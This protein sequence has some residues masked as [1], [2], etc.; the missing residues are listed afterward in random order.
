MYLLEPEKL[1]H[2]DYG[3]TPAEALRNCI[4]HLMV[5][6]PSLRDLATGRGRAT[7]QIFYAHCLVRFRDG[8]D[9][10]ALPPVVLKAA[11]TEAGSW[12]A[13]MD[14]D[15]EEK[16][17]EEALED[18]VFLDQAAV[19]QFIA[20]YI[21]P[22]LVSTEET[23]TNVAW[24]K[25]KARF[26]GFLRTQP[27]DWLER[28]PLMPQHAMETLFEM[29]AEH[30][31]RARLLA[32]IDARFADP[33]ADS[34]KNTQ[35]DQSAA[36]RHRFW[37]LQCFFFETPSLSRAWSELRLDPAVVLDI[38]DRIGWFGAKE[39]AYQ[40]PLSP[41]A[42]FRILDTF[43]T[44]WPPVPLPNGF[45][46]SSPPGERAFRF[47]TDVIWKIGSADLDR[48]LP[49]LDNMLGDSR[50][51]VFRAQLLT[52]RAE[53]LH[54]LALRD[55]AAPSPAQI[56]AMLDRHQVATVED[57]RALMVEELAALQGWLR[58]SE[59]DPLDTFYEG[60][61]HVDENTGRNRVVDRLYARMMALGLSV[62]IER[63]MADENRCD[64]TVSA[65]LPGI[66]RLLVVEVKGQWSSRLFTA[67]S[68]QLA[69]RY[70]IH[71]NAAGQGIYLVF[72]YGADVPV[73]GLRTTGISSARA[74]REAILAEMPEQLQAAISVVV[75]DLSRAAATVA[76]AA[77]GRQQVGS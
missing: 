58:G 70:A 46:T 35:Q 50:F 5:H 63:H 75:L 24:L 12:P 53:T 28:Y 66:Q 52:L 74:L 71:P 49:V 61:A 48:K 16:A 73:A 39:N 1:A 40:L 60:G 2:M 10:T 32:L 20:A 67:A 30:G 13:F 76:P 55:F 4:P 8:S 69:E 41:E 27:L 7:A 65:T 51:D 3:A 34:G 22:A 68:A 18:A 38:Q 64:I 15:A 31:D 45:G 19:D 54:A 14:N 57:L 59:T 6:S 21:E 11:Y 29:A 25:R 56:V 42:I 33:V 44:A 62:E 36:R 9:L 37:A 26:R 72:W 17:F 77:R 43:V 23:P 47:F